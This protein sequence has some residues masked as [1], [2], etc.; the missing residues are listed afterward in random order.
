MFPPPPTS[1]NLILAQ[2]GY[3]CHG[4]QNL[5]LGEKNL[6]IDTP[7]ATFSQ[8]TCTPEKMYVPN[9]WKNKKHK[10][11]MSIHTTYVHIVD[12]VLICEQDLFQ[13]FVL[14]QSRTFKN[15]TSCHCETFGF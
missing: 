6:K 8:I 15:L 10:M 7:I 11:F 4:P 1:V 12:G 2:K 14:L 13:S 9:F 3:V 5:S